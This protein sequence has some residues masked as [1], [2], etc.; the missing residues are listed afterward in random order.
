[1]LVNPGAADSLGHP[2]YPDWGSESLRSPVHPCWPGYCV[3][4]FWALIFLSVKGDSRTT[5]PRHSRMDKCSGVHFCSLRTFLCG[6]WT[7]WCESGSDPVCTEVMWP[8]NPWVL[9]MPSDHFGPH[10]SIKATQLMCYNREGQIIF[11]IGSVYFTLSIVFY[12]F[13]YKLR[14][15]PIAWNIQDIP[16]SRLWHVKV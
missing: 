1:M 8:W 7:N 15:L 9:N 6:G 12:C 3:P 11:R 16:F 4:F 2:T 14:M 13:C 10:W 5:F